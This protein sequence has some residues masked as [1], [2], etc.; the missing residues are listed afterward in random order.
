MPAF[1]LRSKQPLTPTTGKPAQCRKSKRIHKV[2]SA[3][4]QCRKSKRIHKVQIPLL[5]RNIPNLADLTEN[6]DKEPNIEET[7][8]NKHHTPEELYDAI[9]KAVPLEAG[10]S[11]GDYADKHSK[12]VNY[13]DYG[14]NGDNVSS[15]TVTTV[16]T[17]RQQSST[18]CPRKCARG[19][20]SE[21]L[22]SLRQGARES[23][24]EARH[25]CVG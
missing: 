15:T 25:L 22:L 23:A 3:L 14:D 5:Q 4:A 12:V 20:A 24:Q 1:R 8:A 6:L 10:Q 19:S 7:M 2:R 9:P 18:G 11:V 16:T 13:G 21:R 17:C